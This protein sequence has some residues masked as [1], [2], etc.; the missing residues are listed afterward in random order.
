MYYIGN[1]YENKCLMVVKRELDVWLNKIYY[2]L[3]GI[4]MSGHVRL[5]ASPTDPEVT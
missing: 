5:P 1:I 3:M 2:E 4:D